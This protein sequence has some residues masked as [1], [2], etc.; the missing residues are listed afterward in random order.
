MQ[1]SYR[2]M[3]PLAAQQMTSAQPLMTSRSPML[4]PQS[5]FSVMQQQQQQ[6]QD[7][8]SQLGIGGSNELHMLS[9]AGIFPDFGR[10]AASTKEMGGSS[11]PSEGRGGDGSEPMYLKSGSDEGK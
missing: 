11:G 1:S 10:S 2:Y 6:Q 5:S 9:G 7:L 4:Y 8:H 3:Q